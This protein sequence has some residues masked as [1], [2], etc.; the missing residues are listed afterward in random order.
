MKIWLLQ[1][2]EQ[3][4]IGQGARKLRT[5]LLAEKLI[6]RG[7]TV[8][9]WTS[10]FDHLRKRW[11]F[12][13]DTIFTA[14]PSL[15]IHAL[16]GMAYRR[17]FSLARFLDHRII[18][19]KFNRLVKTYEKPDLIVA[20]LPAHDLADKAV[21]Y[22]Q[23]WGIPI[24]IDVRDKWPHNFVDIAPNA[25]KWIARI[26]LSSDFRM[27]YRALSK[28]TA[29]T[30]MT[31]PLLDWGLHNGSRERGPF[32]RVFYLGTYREKLRIISPDL[33]AL[34]TT[35]LNGKFVVTFVGTFSSYHNPEIVISIAE[36]LAHITGIVFVLAGDGD[37]RDSLQR[38]AANLN[39][40]IFTGWLDSAGISAV[41]RSSHLGLCTT[42][43]HSERFF[44]PNKVFTYLSEGVPIASIFDGELR[45]IIKDKVI[46]FN[47][48]CD[49]ELASGIR[50]IFADKDL[51]H[52]MSVNAKCFFELECDSNKIYDNY[53]INL[54]NIFLQNLNNSDHSK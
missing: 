36:K 13:Q 34:I 50:N 42:G 53:A 20:S 2:G 22:A 51:H 16:K 29:I 38:R 25:L 54:E 23:S 32:D 37:L 4:P 33:D 18:A 35:R 12:D 39:N 5:E 9:W 43:K 17:N 15:T 49:E 21:G 14:S 26:V 31:S 11:Y 28:A 19:R 47:Y 44:L 10:C 52:K 6:E 48:D 1:T 30:S 40:V 8:T 41:L 3:L 24:V 7:H 27:T 45:E 46:G